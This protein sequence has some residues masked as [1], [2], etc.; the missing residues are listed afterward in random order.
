MTTATMH[1]RLDVYTTAHSSIEKNR[2]GH[3][4]RKRTQLV[5]MLARLLLPT[6]IYIPYVI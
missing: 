6:H 3:S 4:Y 5:L 2:K 1:K